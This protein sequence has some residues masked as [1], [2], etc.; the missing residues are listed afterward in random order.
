MVKK[1]NKSESSWECK[2]VLEIIPIT[3]EINCYR[4]TE[5]VNGK[6]TSVLEGFTRDSKIGVDE[7]VKDEGSMM[8]CKPE[9]YD[10]NRNTPFGYYS[11]DWDVQKSYII[12]KP[13]TFLLSCPN[14]DYTDKAIFIVYKVNEGRLMDIHGN[15]L[16]QGIVFNDISSV[17]NGTY[18]LEALLPVLEKHPKVR[19]LS[20]G[21][22]AIPY[23]NATENTT[24]YIHFMYMPDEEEFDRAVKSKRDLHSYAAEQLNLNKFKIES[25]DD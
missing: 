2:R 5:Y 25:E 15:Y 4:L 22:R 14:Y 23:Y 18:D 10:F 1:I 12:E 3:T 13:F 24:H 9:I 16:P 19:M 6:E 7:N 8:F 20:E 11:A 17:D 21:L